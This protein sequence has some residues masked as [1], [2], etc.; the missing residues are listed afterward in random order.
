M[1]IHECSAIDCDRP[2][3]FHLLLEGDMQL[4]KD[5]PAPIIKAYYCRDHILIKLENLVTR[6]REGMR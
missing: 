4:Q 6:F 2:G 5:Q 3:I 1:T